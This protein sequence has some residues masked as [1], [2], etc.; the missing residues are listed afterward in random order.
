MGMGRTGF[1][2]LL[3]IAITI[4]I[5]LVLWSVLHVPV[6]FGF[7]FLPLFF[8][9]GNWFGRRRAQSGGAA[10]RTCPQ[11]GFASADPEVRHCP[12]DGTRV[13]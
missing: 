9:L 10:W 1:W 6:F 5:T 8:G 11:C 12:R 3:S 7:L 13:V 4:G 2:L